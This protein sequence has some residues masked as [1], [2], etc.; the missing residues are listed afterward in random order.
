MREDKWIV[1]QA[2]GEDLGVYVLNDLSEVTTLPT[3]HYSSY[4]AT[5]C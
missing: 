4:Q 5:T 3:L 2:V 1:K